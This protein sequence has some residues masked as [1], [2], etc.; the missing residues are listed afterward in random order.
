MYA[1]TQAE[2][3]EDEEDRETVVLSD[4]EEEEGPL[5][6]KTVAGVKATRKPSR[7]AAVEVD[8]TSPP[9][10]RESEREEAEAGTPRAGQATVQG[11]R[12]FWAM[13]SCGILEFVIS[14]M[15][16]LGFIVCH[17]LYSFWD[18]SFELSW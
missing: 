14:S 11:V 10:R 4:E 13:N 2:E 12:M 18:S 9:S 5:V 17:V 15:S 3:E 1:T 7:A 8:L 6:T 16:V